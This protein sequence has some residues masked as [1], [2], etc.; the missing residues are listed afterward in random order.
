[1]KELRSIFCLLIIV[2]VVSCENK[3]NVDVVQFNP[4]PSPEI[5]NLATCENLFKIVT[6]RW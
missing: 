3:D 1:M 5:T 2:S 6:S 4:P